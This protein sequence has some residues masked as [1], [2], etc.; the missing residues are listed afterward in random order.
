MIL[1]LDISL[2]GT[3]VVVLDMAGDICLKSTIVPKNI[4]LDRMELIDRRIDSLILTYSPTLV[5]LEGYAFSMNMTGNSERKEL[6]GILKYKFHKSKIPVVIVSPMSLK[7]FITGSGK[8]D[9]NK[10]MLA[11]YKKWAIEF[12]DDNQTDAYGLARIGL[13]IKNKNVK[14]L[15]YE[16]EVIKVCTRGNNAK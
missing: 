7:K 14:L 2:N 1:G 3:G 10:I 5:V 9:K 11:A 13:A 12:D 16:Q 4:G 6:T 15:S 8:G